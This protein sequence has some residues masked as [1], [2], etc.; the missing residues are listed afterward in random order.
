MSKYKCIRKC[1]YIGRKFNIGD[2]VN[3]DHNPG[4]HF[5]EVEE[6]VLVTIDLAP[7][8]DPFK[9]ADPKKDVRSFAEMQKQSSNNLG[10]FASSIAKEQPITDMRNLKRP[11]ESQGSTETVKRLKKTSAKG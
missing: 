11:Q 10:G 2:V 4:H 1:H 8:V 9:L 3:F 5:D 7:K 6:S